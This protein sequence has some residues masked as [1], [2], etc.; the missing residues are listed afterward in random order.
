[1]A[2]IRLVPD[3]LSIQ[4]EQQRVREETLWATDDEIRAWLE[5]A[6]PGWV[7]C[8]ERTRHGYTRAKRGERLHFTS[9]T[10]ETPNRPSYYVRRVLCPDC[11]AVEIVE[12]WVFIPKKGTRNKIGDARMVHS[13]PNYIDK[14]YLAV[15][16]TG[17]MRTTTLREI[18]VMETMVGID[19]R[20]I[21][22]EIVAYQA[23]RLQVVSAS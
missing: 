17:R 9:K 1:M 3:R 20:E 12:W 6:H 4:G 13:Y 21:D 8:K 10:K 11:Q 15:A 23:E 14:N 2:D 19:L 22:N 7:I 18:I 16:G 5:A